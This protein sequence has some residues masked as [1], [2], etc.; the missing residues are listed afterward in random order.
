[1]RLQRTALRAAA[2]AP[3]RWAARAG[4]M[5]RVFVSA[6]STLVVAS[7]LAPSAAMAS[8]TSFEYGGNT[9]SALA[10]LRE[11]GVQTLALDVHPGVQVTSPRDFELLQNAEGAIVGAGDLRAGFR[12][13]AL[14]YLQIAPI[15]DDWQRYFEGADSR[16]AVLA[17][18]QRLF[19][20]EPGLQ[21]RSV[22]VRNI[23]VN[24]TELGEHERTLLEHYGQWRGTYTDSKGY[25]H[26]T[27]NFEAGRL[28]EVTRRW[29]PAPL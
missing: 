5:R 15:H 10:T 12:G 3:D 6:L 13:E 2:E 28:S 18:L 27:L 24:L 8:D 4:G 26:L 19:L 11:L 20:S 17:G 22:A 7:F 25:W 23:H 21:V 1:M 29:L 16:S 14:D 9:Q